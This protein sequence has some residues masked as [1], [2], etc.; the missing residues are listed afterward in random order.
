[1]LV[2]ITF[3]IAN[4]Y[5]DDTSIVLFKYHKLYDNYIHDTPTNL[6][7]ISINNA[8]YRESSVP[9]NMDGIFALEM[10]P[11]YYNVSINNNNYLLDWN[12]FYNYHKIMIPYHKLND[13]VISNS[14]LV[15]MKYNYSYEHILHITYQNI[16]TKSFNIITFNINIDGNVYSEKTN[17][18]VSIYLKKKL[19]TGTHFIEITTNSKQ[20]WCSCPSMKNGYTNCRYFYAWIEPVYK[21]NTYIPIYDNSTSIGIYAY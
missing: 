9:S 3:I 17:H 18:G 19:E 21:I 13:I 7:F 1:M 20:Y 16:L 14:T 12:I 6:T 11:A 8:K 2:F 4:L 10:K 15:N 5:L